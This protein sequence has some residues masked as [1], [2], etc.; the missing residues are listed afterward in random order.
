M[1]YAGAF[2]ND[3]WQYTPDPACAAFCTVQNNPTKSIEEKDLSG[4]L[5]YPN[6]S[7]ENLIISANAEKISVKIFDQA[8][9]EI[10]PLIL[11]NSTGKI[12]LSVARLAE[13]IYYL[14]I[15]LDGRYSR[16]KII[17]QH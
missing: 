9:R 8:G 1:D 6:P 5:V 17:V 4:L 14:K 2:K 10:A 16:K 7:T 11:K 3:L 12:E 15:C 13:G